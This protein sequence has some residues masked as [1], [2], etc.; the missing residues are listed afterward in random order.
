MDNSVV[1]PV[2]TDHD[3]PTVDADTVP[4]K[5]GRKKALAHRT[6]R[7]DAG[8]DP[9]FDAMYQQLAIMQKQL[10][11]MKRSI[12]ETSRAAGKTPSIVLAHPNAPALP[13]V[14]SESTDRLV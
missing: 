11:T 9:K 5:Q 10:N 1:V 2:H 13:S 4:R 7:P 8:H 3:H 12:A 6:N 14:P